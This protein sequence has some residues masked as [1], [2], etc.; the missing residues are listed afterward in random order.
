MRI[1][2][3]RMEMGE[4]KWEVYQIERKRKKYKNWLKNNSEKIES[5]NKKRS[6][7]A[8][9][10]RARVKED[11]IKYKG[12]KCIVCGYCKEIPRAYDFHHRDPKGKEFAISNYT[13]LNTGKLKEEVDKCD[14]LC[15]NCHAELHDKEYIEIRKTMREK[16]DNFM[17][18]CFTKTK[19]KCKVCNNEFETTYYKQYCCS[20]NCRDINNRKVINRPS[21]EE[22]KKMMDEMPMTKIGEK[23][24]VSNNA[25][26]KW[27]KI[28]KIIE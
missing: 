3:K 1:S 20:A 24:G 13:V 28:Y 23:Y 4:E 5:Y 26:K 21:L 10:W 14:L 19:R 2:K 6:N 12:G 17:D 25:V 16:H 8:V 9:F 11:L 18:S 7:Y 15:K 22:L 27:A